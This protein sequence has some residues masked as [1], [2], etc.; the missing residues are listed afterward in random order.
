MSKTTKFTN[1][2]FMELVNAAQRGDANAQSFL[3]ELQGQANQQATKKQKQAAKQEKVSI[4]DKIKCMGAKRQADKLGIATV[5]TLV[6]ANDRGAEIALTLIDGAQQ[7]TD[8]FV[9]GAADLAVT[10]INTVSSATKTVNGTAAKLSTTAVCTVHDAIHV[11]LTGEKITSQRLKAELAEAQNEVSVMQ[12]QL[13]KNAA[14]L[15]SLMEDD[16]DEIII[17][18]K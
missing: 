3:K 5:G 9:D 11:G 1:E 8:S 2:Q 18:E 16:E 7:F 17:I 12:A 10:A 6:E 15:E 4:L 13:A 14:L